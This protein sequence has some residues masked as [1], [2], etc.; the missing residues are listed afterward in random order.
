MGKNQ[1]LNRDLEKIFKVCSFF[2]DV[3]W[4]SNKEDIINFYDKNLSFETKILTH[5][6]C[7]I[8][9]RQTDYRRIWDVGGFIFSEFV[10][11]FIIKKAKFDFDI[12][13]S[14]INCYEWKDVYKLETKDKSGNDRFIFKSTHVTGNNPTL[15][16]DGFNED[17]KPYF[18]S[19]YTASDYYSILRTLTFLK[20]YEYSFLKYL[21]KIIEL[22]ISVP[23]SK[24]KRLL[25]GLYILTYKDNKKKTYGDLN[26]LNKIKNEI[27]GQIKEDN[28]ELNDNEKFQKNFDKFCKNEIYNQ[29]RAWCALRDFLKFE[30]YKEEFVKILNEKGF[31][32]SEKDLNE[33]ELPGDVW[34]NNSLFRTCIFKG[35]NLKDNQEK[36]N[37]LLRIIFEKE[38]IKSGYPEQFDITFDFVPRMCEKNNCSICI[39]GKIKNRSQEK[40]DDNKNNKGKEFDKSC[41]K[42]TSKYCTVALVN[43]G[44]KID[45]L[46][47]KCELIKFSNEIDKN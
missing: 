24:I 25:Y 18:L 5:W 23:E 14:K 40:N 41:I 46:G 38:E 34:N 13:F 32:F 2:D 11:D 35:T 29:K 42:D 47:N 20:K 16:K 39:I 36:L 10:H 30:P 4:K 28:S 37:K 31:V 27:C 8:T 19:R 33:L 9:D 26:D 17:N 43:C 12:F 22:A 1:D 15:I 7:Y 21:N 3:K 6:I 44:Y 45:C